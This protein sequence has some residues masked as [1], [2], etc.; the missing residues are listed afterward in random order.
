[1]MKTALTKRLDH[2]EA[3]FTARLSQGMDMAVLLDALSLEPHDG[4]SEA[5][6]TEA[7]DLVASFV[8]GNGRLDVN[9]PNVAGRIRAA[10]LLRK[11]ET[12]KVNTL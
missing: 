1:M 3:A 11:A 8:D 5:E 6:W 7:L 10:E 12:G 4:I 9:H 2:V